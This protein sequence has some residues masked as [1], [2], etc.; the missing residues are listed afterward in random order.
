[1][2]LRKYMMA[3]PGAGGGGAEQKPKPAD[4][5]PPAVDAKAE[6]P[7]A[8]AAPVVQAATPEK[9]A[10]PV[11]PVAPAKTPAERDQHLDQ[12]AQDLDAKAKRYEEKANAYDAKLERARQK[13]IVAALRQMGADPDIVSDADLLS[14][15][16]KVDPDDDGANAVLL[17]FKEQ[18]PGFF[19]RATVGPQESLSDAV[20]RI[21]E[22]KGLSPSQKER[23]R[24][25][26]E[27]L[28][29]GSQ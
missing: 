20:K 23:K 29:G 16:P 10:E 1:M 18:R 27:K 24:R 21:D 2:R 22:D 11:A 28:M 15:A 12:V 9:K 6:T 7:A 5:Q 26:T 25:M 13:S 4:N 3:E 17:K 8:P 14:L 19:R